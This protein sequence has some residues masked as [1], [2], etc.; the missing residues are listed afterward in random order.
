M[1]PNP[2]TPPVKVNIPHKD[3]ISSFMYKYIKKMVDV[4][5]DGHCQFHAVQVC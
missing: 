4:V 3:K 2:K 1:S 5:G